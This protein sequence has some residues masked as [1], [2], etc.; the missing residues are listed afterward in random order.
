[1]GLKLHRFA[2]CAGA[3]ALIAPASLGLL[4]LAMPTAADHGCCAPEAS[5]A[6]S[7][8][9]CC[10]DKTGSP[11]SVTAPAS[12]VPSAH[13]MPTGKT[14]QAPPLLAAALASPFS[15]SLPTPVLRI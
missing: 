5:F 1:V 15:F 7:P 9:G 10:D 14:P 8:A 12:A 4:C 13:A 6:A 11:S 2:A 3:F